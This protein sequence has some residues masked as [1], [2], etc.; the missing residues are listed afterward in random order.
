MIEH[1]SRNC[2]LTVL[3]TTLCLLLGSCGGSVSPDDTIPIP[4][5]SETALSLRGSLTE[6]GRK[7]SL[8]IYRV[9]F[10]EGTLS[11]TLHEN[12]IY[13]VSI[14]SSTTVG[15]SPFD[16]VL[17]AGGLTGSSINYFGYKY[18]QPNAATEKQH[19]NDQNFQNRFPGQFFLSARARTE[20]SA[21]GGGIASFENQHGITMRPTDDGGSPLYLEPD[22]L[23]MLII[24]D[25]SSVE[26]TLRSASTCG[27]GIVSG[28]E[29][30]DDAN[31]IN[32]DGCDNSCHV[33]N[34]WACENE[35]SICAEMPPFSSSR[36]SSST[37]TT[38]A[39]SWIQVGPP[40]TNSNTCNAECFARGSTCAE[41]NCPVSTAWNGT[42]FT[43]GEQ[44]ISNGSMVIPYPCDNQWGTLQAVDRNYCCCTDPAVSS[45]SS[46]SSSSSSSSSSS[47]SSSSSNSSSPSSVNFA[48][49]DDT[50]TGFR[51]SLTFNGSGNMEDRVINSSAY[52][53]EY[54]AVE[55]PCSYYNEVPSLLPGW[56]FSV[57]PAHTYKVYVAYPTMPNTITFGTVNYSMNFSDTITINQH[58][59]TMDETFEHHSWEYLG[60]YTPSNNTLF[61]GIC[62][63]TSGEVA[64]ADAVGLIDTADEVF[65]PTRLVID[66]SQSGFTT[67]D[68]D[69]LD[70]SYGVYGNEHRTDSSD[71]TGSG[72]FATWS[73]SIPS[74]TYK[75]YVHYPFKYFGAS[76]G[77]PTSVH[78]R[79]MDGTTLVMG[80]EVNQS[81]APT[82][83]SYD[84]EQWQ[85]LATVSLSGG[86]TT[87]QI[88][89]A[90]A[91]WLNA[92]AVLFESLGGGVFSSSLSSV[93]ASTEPIGGC[94]ENYTCSASPQSICAGTWFLTQSECEATCVAPAIPCCNLSQS[95]MCFATETEEACW[96]NGGQP[97]PDE[98]SCRNFCQS[99]RYCC[100]N[101]DFCIDRQWSPNACDFGQYHTQQECEMFCNPGMIPAY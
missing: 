39:N 91:G 81:V 13:L 45:S 59:P 101:N 64:Y 9:T 72:P 43:G 47:P 67:S 15:S 63:S 65:D 49:L 35:P 48:F 14:P 85:L 61:V 22:S 12:A 77:A 95:Y 23:Y 97:F 16:L 92:D 82:G 30:C 83:T 6:V 37:S 76:N 31:L 68:C 28:F 27:D 96:N 33:Q 46:P 99:P 87:V 58:E 50:D 56:E 79:I 88:M 78:Y 66:D 93:S 100:L 74:G 24:N 54:F 4:V 80:A 84:G 75:V 2:R 86:P 21:H 51:P 73:A 26:L 32:G 98:T 69:W 10:P 19:M 55:N 25:P 57:T 94:C 62:P 71:C 11:Q 29:T 36:S 17:S 3:T 70:M 34:G 52:N 18:T 89:N 38:L 41:S 42:S 7:N 20:D 5:G 53:G 44:L 40:H 8:D 90:T 60:Q 1:L